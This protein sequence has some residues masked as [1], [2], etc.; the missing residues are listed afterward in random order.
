MKED[1]ACPVLRIMGV[2]TILVGS[3]LTSQLIVT[4]IAISNAA[5][6]VPAGFSARIEV[7]GMLGTW[8]NYAIVAQ[9]VT[10]V[11]GV[12]LFLLSPA[13]AKLVTRQ[14]ANR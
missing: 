6:S 1:V 13:L 5:R 14:A 7:D 3:I 10:I 2:A 12:V 8:G 4:R 9:A 11:L